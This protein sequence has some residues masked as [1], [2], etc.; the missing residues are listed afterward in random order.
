[1]PWEPPGGATRNQ[2]EPPG[3]S[4][5]ARFLLCAD[6]AL[7]DSL[8][9]A[10][11][12]LADKHGLY[13]DEMLCMGCMGGDRGLLR[14]QVLA[15]VS[16]CLVTQPDYTAALSIA[17]CLNMEEGERGLNTQPNRTAVIGALPL[18]VRVGW[19]GTRALGV[20]AIEEGTGSDSRLNNTWLLFV[21]VCPS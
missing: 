11:P 4:R 20:R 17:G 14:G 18:P 16:H 13:I 8:E 19:R 6:S 1:M 2:E 15:G 10:G 21:V 7:P 3:P 9:R 12:M 5:A